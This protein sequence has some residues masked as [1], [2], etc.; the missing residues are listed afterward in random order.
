[1]RLSEHFTL[2]ELT[3]SATADRHGLTNHPVEEAHLINLRALCMRVLQPLRDHVGRPVTVTSGYR[4]PSVNA[5]VGG[6][7]DSQHTMGQAADIVC[8]DVAALDLA[9]ILSAI[10]LPVDQLIYEVRQQAG[11][12]RTRWLHVSHSRHG[13]RGEIMTA[14]KRPGHRTVTGQG[15]YELEMPGEPGV[16]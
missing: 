12:R 9:H 1:M 8:R 15:L 4:S 10:A 14:F 16:T 13:N 7:A 2:G 3:R 11:G 5:L 6:V